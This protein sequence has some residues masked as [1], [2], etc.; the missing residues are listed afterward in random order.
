MTDPSAPQICQYIGSSM[1]PRLGK[2]GFVGIVHHNIPFNNQL[3]N[4]KAS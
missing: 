4:E 2:P 3:S 1:I